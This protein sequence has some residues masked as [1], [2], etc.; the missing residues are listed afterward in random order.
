[1]AVPFY[2]SSVFYFARSFH[3][4]PGL[5]DGT[6]DDVVVVN[7]ASFAAVM[8]FGSPVVCTVNVS[9]ELALEWQEVLLTAPNHIAVRSNM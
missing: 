1:M 3:V 6:H 2:L 4:D 7:W 8:I 9:T 5:A